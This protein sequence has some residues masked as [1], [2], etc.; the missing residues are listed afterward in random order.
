MAT[1]TYIFSISQPTRTM[2]NYGIKEVRNKDTKT[3]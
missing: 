1:V 2:A 3:E